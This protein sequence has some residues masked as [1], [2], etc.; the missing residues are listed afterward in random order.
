M[1]CPTCKSPAPHQHPAMQHE[2]EVE[3]CRDAY[4]LTPTPQNKPQYIAAVR[5]LLY[6]DPT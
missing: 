3:L 6:K 1:N 5:A 2:G 4:H